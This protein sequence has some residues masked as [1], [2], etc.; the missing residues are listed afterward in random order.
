MLTIIDRNSFVRTCGYFNTGLLQKEMIMQSIYY[1]QRCLGEILFEIEIFWFKRL[2]LKMSCAKQEPFCLD[3]IL[4][5]DVSDI[6][7]AVPKIHY[8]LIW[9]E[10]YC[11]YINHHRKPC[12]LFQRTVRCLSALPANRPTSATCVQRISFPWMVFVNVS[13]IGISIFS[14]ACSRTGGFE[15]AYFDLIF[16][17]NIFIC[18]RYI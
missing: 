12:F 1:H 6:L 17:I 11:N 18:A 14:I 2:H 4:L 16:H 3:N 13:R 9:T 7:R 15:Y 5:M 10:H 8:W